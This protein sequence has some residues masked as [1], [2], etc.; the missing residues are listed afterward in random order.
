MVRSNRGKYTLGGKHI[1]D[2]STIFQRGKT[3]IPISVRDLL[4][5]GEGDKLVWVFE[6]GRIYLE[7]SINRL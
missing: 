2:T 6:A 5:V 7:S 3:H 1:I 4:D